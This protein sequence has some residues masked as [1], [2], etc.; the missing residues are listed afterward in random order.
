MDA[1]RLYPCSSGS[2]LCQLAAAS[3]TLSH[4]G[5]QQERRHQVVHYD[6]ANVAT[7]DITQDVP[8][9]IVRNTGSSTNK[10][11]HALG[12]EYIHNVVIGRQLT[13]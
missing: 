13:V 11:H 1:Q 9:N 7:K 3:S 10:K 5:S 12:C 6:A 8:L 4:I 2:E